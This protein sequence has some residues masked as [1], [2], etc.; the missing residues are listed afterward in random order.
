M[1]FG[2]ILTRRVVEKINGNPEEKIGDKP[3][4]GDAFYP[5]YMIQGAEVRRK[6]QF[7]TMAVHLI[8]NCNNPLT[9]SWFNAGKSFM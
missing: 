8:G 7:T 4:G 2:T 9:T 3:P 5:E 6:D 1:G